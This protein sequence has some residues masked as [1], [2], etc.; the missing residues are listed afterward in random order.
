MWG[1]SPQTCASRGWGARL[2]FAPRAFLSR[3]RGTDGGVQGPTQLH[4]GPEEGPHSLLP[5][6]A[7]VYPS[8]SRDPCSSRLTGASTV[9]SMGLGLSF[10]PEEP[11]VGSHLQVETWSPGWSLGAQV[12]P[13]YHCVC[14]SRVGCPGPSAQ[15]ASEGL[16]AP[17]PVGSDKPG[18]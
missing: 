15:A 12:D 10:S 3:L 16:R 18:L 7:S 6:A 1:A 8:V 13:T 4:T 9:T 2:G 5:L 17:R 14:T 11:Q